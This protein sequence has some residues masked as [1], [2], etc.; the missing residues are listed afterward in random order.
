MV[1]GGG[2]QKITAGRGIWHEEGPAADIDEPTRGLQLWINLSKA[3]KRVEP[4]YQIL[5][6]EEVPERESEGAKVRQLAGGDSSVHLHTPALYVD[7]TISDGGRFTQEIPKGY[8]GFVLVVQGRGRFGANSVEAKSGQL[9]V[10]GPGTDL[11]VEAHEGDVRFVLAG[12]QPHGE[13]VLWNGPF[14]D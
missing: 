6:P 2:L 7:I 11:P 12:G 4:D 8:Q 10:L 13:P 3:N 5:G 1:M 14:V 9:L